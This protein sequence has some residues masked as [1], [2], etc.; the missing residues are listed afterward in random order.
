MENTEE[1]RKAIPPYLRSTLELFTSTLFYRKHYLPQ[2]LKTTA[3]IDVKWKRDGRKVTGGGCQS[4]G[5]GFTLT[6]RQEDLN[7]NAEQSKDGSDSSPPQQEHV[8]ECDTALLQ[9]L[10]CLPA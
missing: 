4:L 2:R 6:S 7:K 9:L 8:R 1:I 10:I 5:K 3:V